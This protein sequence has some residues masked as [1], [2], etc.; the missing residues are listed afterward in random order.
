MVGNTW[1]R[2]GDLQSQVI[3]KDDLQSQV[4]VKDDL[5]SQVLVKDDVIGNTWHRLGDL[6]SQV[7]V[8]DDVVGEHLVQVGGPAITGPCQRRCGG[9]HLAQVGGP[10]ITRLAWVVSQW[11]HVSAMCRGERGQGGG[12]GGGG[13]RIFE[14]F[15]FEDDGFRP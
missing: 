7:L 11:L 1:H 6:Q 12:G 15:Y 9:E 2:L 10:A 8:K 5:Q 13:E 4:I 14:S 3:V